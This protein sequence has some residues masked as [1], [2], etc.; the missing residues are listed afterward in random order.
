LKT[1]KNECGMPNWKIKQKAWKWPSKP[2][3]RISWPALL[4][5][6][7]KVTTLKPWGE[8]WM[9]AA[10]WGNWTRS[11]RLSSRRRP[12][13]KWKKI[14]RDSWLESRL[15]GTSSY[16]LRTIWR[17]SLTGTSR[18]CQCPKPSLIGFRV[19]ANEW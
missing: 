7:R 14:G 13:Y 18:T 12:S 16:A 10:K 6:R 19:S 9:I 15:T 11:C 17:R 4:R 1:T 3:H 5:R 8:R 2:S